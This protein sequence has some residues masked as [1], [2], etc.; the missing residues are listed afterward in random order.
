MIH[1]GGAWFGELVI[2][3]W[4][5]ARFDGPIVQ[6]SVTS[7]LRAL[8][9]QRAVVCVE[10]FTNRGRGRDSSSSVTCDGKFLIP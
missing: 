2:F 10:D 4:A 9:I 6:Y 5:G 3:V 7:S 1:G 8:N